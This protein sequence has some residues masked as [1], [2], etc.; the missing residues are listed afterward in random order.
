MEE[1][2][3]RVGGMER[4]TGSSTDSSSPSSAS[5]KEKEKEEEEEEEIEGYV[6]DS[7]YS[8]DSPRSICPV[9]SK[10]GTGM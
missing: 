1:M 8:T 3:R 9:M 10:D 7:L 4:I 2:L 6:A 5:E